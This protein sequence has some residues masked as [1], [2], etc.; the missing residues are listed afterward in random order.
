MP[1]NSFKE[2]EKESSKQFDEREKRVRDNVNHS[3][4]FFHFIGDIL[5]LF[6]PKLFSIFVNVTG[7]NGPKQ[8]RENDPKGGPST[9]GDDLR[10]KYPNTL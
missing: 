6:L 10:P 9:D 8:D 7:G 5:E 4:G 3:V 2:L 1:T